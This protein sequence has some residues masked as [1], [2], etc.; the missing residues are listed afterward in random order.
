VSQRVR[1]T[2]EPPHW[3]PE[4]ARQAGSENDR[5]DSSGLCA[6][7]WGTHHGCHSSQCFRSGPSVSS[8]RPEQYSRSS[9]WDRPRRSI[10]TRLG[11][12]GTVAVATIALIVTACEQPRPCSQLR[13]TE[14]WRLTTV[15]FG[16]SQAAFWV[17]TM[18]N[19]DNGWARG[20]VGSFSPRT[21]HVRMRTAGDSMR[22]VM[23]DSAPAAPAHTY[24][25]AGQCRGDGSVAGEYEVTRT[26]PVSAL[27][28]WTMRPTHEPP[29]NEHGPAT[30]GQQARQPPPLGAASAEVTDSTA[31]RKHRVHSILY[32]SGLL[33]GLAFLIWL[34][35]TLTT[36][37]RGYTHVATFHNRREAED[38]LAQLQAVGIPGEL[39][40][41]MTGSRSM[42]PRTYGT[43]RLLVPD[44]HVDEAVRVLRSRETERS[45]ETRESGFAGD[46]AR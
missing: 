28:T 38:V 7:T 31:L 36:D 12:R 33:V 41:H 45:T 2:G 19:D 35:S 40:D 42:G 11:P 22:L 44:K 13:Q 21:K 34:V 18:Y 37:P 4:K 14:V 5:S 39:D 20:T 43:M 26:G 10:M 9:T 8:Y 25:M 46:E 24:T 27:G 30:Q 17:V 32:V 29:D 6:V 3:L 16:T 23:T 1:F 15:G